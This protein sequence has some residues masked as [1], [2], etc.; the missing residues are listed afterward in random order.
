[1]KERATRVQQVSPYQIHW[2]ICAKDNYHISVCIFSH[3]M[4]FRESTAGV[5]TGSQMVLKGEWCQRY[6]SRSRTKAL[7]SRRWCPKWWIT[8]QKQQ[9][10]M[11]RLFP[12]NC[13]NLGGGIFSCK[14]SVQKRHTFQLFNNQFQFPM[15]LLQCTEFNKGPSTPIPFFFFFWQLSRRTL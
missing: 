10:I 7:A 4:Q 13:L 8:D 3:L 9:S 11:V 14:L 2:I 1:M 6:L 15:K 12:D 5:L